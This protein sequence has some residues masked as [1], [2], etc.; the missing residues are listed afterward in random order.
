[1]GPSWVKMIWILLFSSLLSHETVFGPERKL[2]C[3]E[4]NARLVISWM[5]CAL[6]FDSKFNELNW[7]EIREPLCCSRRICSR[8]A[9]LGYMTGQPMLPSLFFHVH[10]IYLHGITVAFNRQDSSKLMVFDDFLLWKS[11]ITNCST[12][13]GLSQFVEDTVCIA[14][15]NLFDHFKVARFCMC[16]LG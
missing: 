8:P 16:L 11:G 14:T 9:S 7:F 6:L 13:S 1:M 15:R 3:A 5:I 2:H 10:L 12:L 4:A